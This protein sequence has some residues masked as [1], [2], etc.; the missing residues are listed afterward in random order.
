M[1]TKRTRATRNRREDA[2]PTWATRL[3]EHGE[4][5]S[6]DSDDYDAFVSWMYFGDHVEGLPDDRGEQMR[7]VMNRPTTTEKT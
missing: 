4:R 5:P 6:P 1:P 2:E 7:L 3:R